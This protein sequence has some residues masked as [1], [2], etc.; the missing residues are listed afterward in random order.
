LGETILKDMTGSNAYEYTFRK[1]SNAITM[2]SKT[3]VTI[4]GET[5]LIK[6]EPL[7][8][9]IIFAAQS[10]G[11]IDCPSVFRYELCSY[12][13]ALFDTTM[14]MQQ[15]NKP[16]LA[17]AIWSLVNQDEIPN[18]PDRVQYV[19]DGGALL[20]RIPWPSSSI[21]YSQLCHMNR[22]Y[23]NKKYSNAII[24]FDGYGQTS[25]KSTAHSRR[26]GGKVAAAIKFDDRMPLVMKKELFL[27]NKD[28][29]QRFINMLSEHLEER[30]RAPF[31][32]MEMQMSLLQRQPVSSASRQDTVLIGD[33]T[34]LL[35]LLCYHANLKS[36]ELIFAPEPKKGAKKRRIWHIKQVKQS[37]GPAICRNILLLH[38]MLGCDT[39]S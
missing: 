17:D 37:L 34:D 22:D 19:L 25:T 35:V 29:K 7:F 16:Q 21:T 15:A 13:P 31:I 5:I 1:K 20:H 3:K 28:N 2:A 32:Q 9:R 26:S 33:D 30:G 18:F 36:H 12:P 8:Q 23:V 6:P 27:A 14:M 4:N 38:A 10:K 39:T 24:V 11:T